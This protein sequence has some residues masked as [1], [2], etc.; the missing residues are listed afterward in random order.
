MSD[1]TATTAFRT[2]YL[3]RG[4]ALRFTWQSTGQGKSARRY[5]PPTDYTVHKMRA[6]LRPE[7]ALAEPELRLI[8]MIEVFLLITFFPLGFA[9]T[10]YNKL[11]GPCVGMSSLVFFAWWGLVAGL[12]YA[13]L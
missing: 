12:L 4:T 6:A 10:R 11:F 9:L 2:T 3:G 5:G 8:R 13:F 1:A 7:M